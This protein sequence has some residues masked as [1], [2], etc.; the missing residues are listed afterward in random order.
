MEKVW[1]RVPIHKNL[2]ERRPHMLS[3]RSEFSLDTGLQ[4]KKYLRSTFHVLLRG[5]MLLPAGYVRSVFKKSWTVPQV[6]R[7]P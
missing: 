4:N 2:C 7:H 6:A 1:E 5:W 3:Q